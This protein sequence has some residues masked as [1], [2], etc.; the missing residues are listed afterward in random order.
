[1]TPILSEIKKILKLEPLKNLIS[2]YGFEFNLLLVYLA[3][4]GKNSCNDRDILIYSQVDKGS[5]T[6][7]LS[8]HRA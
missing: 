4:L 2:S 8:Q 3:S 7:N 5:F 1:M 6:P